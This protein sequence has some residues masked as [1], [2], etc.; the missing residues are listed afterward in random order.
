MIIRVDEAEKARKMKEDS[1]F[2]EAR[3]DWRTDLT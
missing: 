1:D 2:T 3:S